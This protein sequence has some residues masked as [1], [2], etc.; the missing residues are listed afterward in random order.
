MATAQD[1]LARKQ[2]Y[3][4]ALQPEAV[5]LRVAAYCRVSTDSDD[6]LN[7]FDAQQNH[8]NEY[9]RSQERWEMVDIY[10]DEGI[11]GTSAQKR[12]DF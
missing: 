1:N 3:I 11:T 6:Q 2:I 10:A 12:D 7:S 5:A 8:Y 9:I 4:P